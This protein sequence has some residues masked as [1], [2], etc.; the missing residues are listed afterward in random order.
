MTHG[1]CTLSV[2]WITDTKHVII[3]WL[4]Y[5]PQKPGNTV[6]SFCLLHLFNFVNYHH[7]NINIWSITYKIK[8]SRNDVRK[9]ILYIQFNFCAEK[10]VIDVQKVDQL[11][12]GAFATDFW[13]TNKVINSIVRMKESLPRDLPWNPNYHLFIGILHTPEKEDR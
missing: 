5:L 7:I 2:S 11:Q 9:L 8:E 13:P 1:K 12:K 4:L 6:N 3:S 10:A